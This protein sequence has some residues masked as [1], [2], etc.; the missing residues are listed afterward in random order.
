MKID[1]IPASYPIPLDALSDQ[2]FGFVGGT[3]SGKT[4]TAGTAVERILWN[5]GRVIIF[6]PTDVWYGLR[7]AANGSDA[8]FP[9]ILIGGE[10]G[11][12]P[13]GPNSGAVI[14][15]TIAK[16]DASFVVCTATLKTKAAERRF[17]LAALEALYQHANK[18][19]T[20]VVFDEADMWAPQVIRDKEGEATK[21]YAMMETIVRRGRVRGLLSW[22]ISQ[23]PAVLAW[24]VLSM[25]DAIVAMRFTSGPDREAVARWI[26]DQTDAET[27]KRLKAKMPGYH[28]GQGLVWVPRHKILADFEFPAK[29]TFD[30][31]ATPKRGDKKRSASISK[32]DLG[33]LRQKLK[34]VE[35]E[36]NANNP[37]L[38][39]A[40]VAK[41]RAEIAALNRKAQQPL[42]GMASR[43]EV[44][45]ERK[46]AF[47]NGVAAGRKEAADELRAQ[48][49]E[50]AKVIGHGMGVIAD[51]II[52]K[53]PKEAVFAPRMIP[54]VNVIKGPAPRMIAAPA[55]RASSA[56]D[57][58]LPVGEKAILI[59][60]AQYGS[61]Q[62]DTISILTG[63]KR[64]SRDAY[65]QRLR[66]KGYVRKDG[67]TVSATPEGIAALGSDYEPM[68]TGPALVEYWRTKLPQ[69]EWAMLEI[70]LKNY[71]HYVARD[72]MSADSD[73]KRSSRDAYIQRLK[74]RRLVETSSDGVRAADILVA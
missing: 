40:E 32:L 19:P 39:R 64:S 68:P 11:D 20:L 1:R 55:P 69:G 8:G 38:L 47:Q 54:P 49:V 17:M 6:D 13:I 71:P 46:A 7:S 50:M 74:A 52:A 16:A 15:E 4:Y 23:R 43:E 31:S 73:Y 72:I 59:A 26:S 21:L 62:P 48:A 24:D 22:L 42:P 10:R 9:I 41:L 60:A 29:V 12:I 67:Q 66:E 3:G 5:K 28:T 56:G 44:E 61:V 27:A 53:A 58:R 34:S 45:A 35:E 57:S 70:A 33:A 18:E 65:V 2:R 51:G 14:G 36:A 30:S 63:Y 25:M 37:N